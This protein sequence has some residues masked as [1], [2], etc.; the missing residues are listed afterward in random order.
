LEGLLVEVR[1]FIAVQEKRRDEEKGAVPG[2]QRR[3][4]DC[5]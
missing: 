2:H 5:S 1:V 4:K 3:F